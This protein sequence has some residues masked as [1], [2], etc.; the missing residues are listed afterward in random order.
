[1]IKEI[2]IGV[3]IFICTGIL[4]SVFLLLQR[5]IKRLLSRINHLMLCSFA[6]FEAFKEQGINGEVKTEFERLKEQI[7]KD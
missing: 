5:Q 3:V 7:I 2:I 6:I 4:T 1:M